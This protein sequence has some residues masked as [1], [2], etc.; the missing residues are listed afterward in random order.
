MKKIISFI[1]L[2]SIT[3]A[4]AA[5]DYKKKGYDIDSDEKNKKYKINLKSG[6]KDDRRFY[7]GERTEVIPHDIETVFNSV[8]NFDE[9]CNNDYKDR[10][11][12]SDKKKNCKYHNSNLVESVFY[13]N[14]KKPYT[15]EKNEV[16]RFLVERRIYNRESFNHID[17]I[18]VYREKDENGKQVIRI[19]QKMLNDKQA[20]AYLKDP[21][22]R[23][24][25]FKKAYSEFRLVGVDNKTTNLTYHYTS[26]TTH[27]LLNKSVAVSKVF[28]NMAK[29]ID[30]LFH[31]ITKEAAIHSSEKVVSTNKK[32][33]KSVN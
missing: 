8:I 11:K 33:R 10:R 25:V 5:P 18:Q 27:W 23:D 7:Q 30:L 13:R 16:D 22:D 28:S 6:K 3:Q 31:S 32:S 29:S 14:F 19:T 1:I 17:L 20:K 24:T 2:A 4:M 9:K 26:E 15:K 12:F 21:N